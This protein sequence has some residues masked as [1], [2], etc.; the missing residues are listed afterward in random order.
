MRGLTVIDEV[1]EGAE[2]LTAPGM[3][4][5]AGT[6]PEGAKC[7]ACRFYGYTYLKPNGDAANKVS[8]CEKFYKA[9]RRH[10]QTLET[11]QLGCKYFEVKAKA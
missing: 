4:H 9:T 2:K 7:G 3:A 6:G 10:G 5:W 8:S 11:R 1:L